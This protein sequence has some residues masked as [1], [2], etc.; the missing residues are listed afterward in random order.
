MLKSF[1]ILAGN[2][3]L[4]PIVNLPQDPHHLKLSNSATL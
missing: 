1:R 4:I 2:P 3:S